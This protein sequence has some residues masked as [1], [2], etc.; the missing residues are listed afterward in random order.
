MGFLKI[1]KVGGLTREGALLSE[2]IHRLGQ[3]I[4]SENEEISS[5]TR[6][7]LIALGKQ[8]IY[9]YS[10]LDSYIHKGITKHHDEA[11][12]F[13]VMFTAYCYGCDGNLWNWEQI[14]HLSQG[15]WGSMENTPAEFELSNVPLIEI[16]INQIKNFLMN[17]SHSSTA[18]GGP[19]SS[20]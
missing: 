4:S 11:T 12:K 8:Y 3:Y 16:S 18:S 17:I 19:M 9:M 2:P 5:S 13:L 1:W 20:R 14:R 10:F 15:L 7:D 6:T